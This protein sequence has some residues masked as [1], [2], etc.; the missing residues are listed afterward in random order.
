MTSVPCAVK[1][2]Q[3]YFFSIIYIILLYYII[4]HYIILHMYVYGIY[5]IK[6]NKHSTFQ[7]LSSSRSYRITF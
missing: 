1:T 2:F 3:D 7:L 4:L 5:G 6:K